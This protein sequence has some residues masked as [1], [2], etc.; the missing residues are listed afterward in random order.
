MKAMA[1][2]EVGVGAGLLGGAADVPE[3][4]RR[5]SERRTSPAAWAKGV[6]SWFS[7]Q[8]LRP[9]RFITQVHAAKNTPLAEVLY[10]STG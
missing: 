3:D 2:R 10:Y 4:P 7:P 6:V 8:G 5:C 9:A 1:G